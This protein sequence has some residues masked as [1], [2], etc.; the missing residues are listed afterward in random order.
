MPDC[1]AC[2]APLPG[3]ALICQFCEVR[4]D[5]DL[6]PVHEVSVHGA[7]SGR[8]CPCCQIALISINVAAGERF[9]L[10]RCERCHGLFFD[11]EE[12]P[13]LLDQSVAEAFQID[14]QRLT[15]LNDEALDVCHGSGYRACP[16]CGELMNR[17]NAGTR[18]GVVTDQCRAHGIWLDGGEL[19]R[20]FEWKR[21]GG[22][23]QD[24]RDA[25]DVQGTASDFVYEPAEDESRTIGEQLQDGFWHVLSE[26]YH[27]LR[28]R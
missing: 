20:L 15:A 4:N 1:R 3:T 9:V 18:S 7:N 14:Y 27:I 13:N 5:V 11:P 23:L 21:V 19:R 16:V 6:R 26:I 10:E 28:D 2:G 8:T 12:L 24:K 17:V 25:L 22:E